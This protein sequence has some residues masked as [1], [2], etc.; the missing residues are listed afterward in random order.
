MSPSTD[1]PTHPEKSQMKRTQP[2]SS[3][4]LP[5]PHWRAVRVGLNNPAFLSHVCIMKKMH[6]L[7][8]YRRPHQYISIYGRNFA[9]NKKAGEKSQDSSGF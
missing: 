3:Q 1:G 8:T 9:F 7:P 5:L 6:L 2:A 4:G